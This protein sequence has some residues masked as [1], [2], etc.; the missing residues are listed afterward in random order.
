MGAAT[1]QDGERLEVMLQRADAAM[2]TEK[3]A[4]YGEPG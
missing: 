1:A 2:Y 3:R 4:H